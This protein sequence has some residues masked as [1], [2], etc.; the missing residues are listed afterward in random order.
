M[1]KRRRFLIASRR[2]K[3]AA[4]RRLCVETQEL[5]NKIASGE[6][7]AFRRLCVETLVVEALMVF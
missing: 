5:I 7:A 6:P 2:H 1:L 4:F 3:P